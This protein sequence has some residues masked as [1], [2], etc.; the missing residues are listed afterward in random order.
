[1]DAEEKSVCVGIVVW[2]IL[3]YCVSQ[4]SACLKS[5]SCESGD[6]FISAILA[7]S[8]VAPAWLASIISKDFFKD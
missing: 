3:A 8:A 5:N 1:M 7:I 2:L 4:N 6:F